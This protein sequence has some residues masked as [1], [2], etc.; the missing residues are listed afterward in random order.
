MRQHTNRKKDPLTTYPTQ[1]L[2]VQHRR[3]ITQKSID[4]SKV[5]VAQM[6]NEEAL[7]RWFTIK[8]FEEN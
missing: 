8:E 3:N 4:A 2:E 5:D 6:D 7:R 1:Y